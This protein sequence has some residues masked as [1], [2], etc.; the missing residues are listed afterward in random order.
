MRLVIQSDDRVDAPVVS[1][2]LRDDGGLVLGSVS[3]G[4]D[5]LGWRRVAGE[6]ELRFRLERLPLADGRFHLRLALADA[7]SGRLLHSL[8]DA[9]RFFVFPVGRRD[10][11]GA[12]RRSLV[13]AGDRGRRANSRPVSSHAVP[14]SGRS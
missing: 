8:D 4:T 11:R 10:R 1:L 7:A 14:R 12:A 2:E 3:Q 9:V 6:R 5:E 13:A